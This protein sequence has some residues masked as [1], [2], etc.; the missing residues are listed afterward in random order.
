AAGV[1]L[2]SGLAVLTKL[3]GATAGVVAAAT[4]ALDGIR[5]AT[6]RSAVARIAVVAAVVAGLSGWFYAR[7]L[8]IYGALQP[9]GLPAHQIM[10]DMPPGE[11]GLIDFVWIPLAT[12]THPN[13][14]DPHLLHSVWGGT[15]ASVW[16]DAHRYFLP[17]DSE[18]VTRLGTACLLLALLPTAA[19]AV[20]LAGGLRRSLRDP[21]A[22]DTPQLLLVAVTLAGYAVY[23]WQNPWFA[24]VKGTSLLGLS[25]P[26][27]YYAS[28]ALDRW[29]QRGGAR[30][31]LTW[32]G[33]AALTA[34]VVLSCSF[35]LAFEKAE[36]SG[37]EWRVP[38]VR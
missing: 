34:A 2:A 33:L 32:A 3:T 17:R 26:F 16:F 36:V 19:F 29:L 35:N 4:Y 11:R 6:A 24:V 9:F 25:L 1:G 10:F 8:L 38:E 23:N 20:G 18:T 14:L 21:L 30:A 37:L 5:S 7:N 15:Y 28:D 12:W 31:L 27:A 22:P 13:L